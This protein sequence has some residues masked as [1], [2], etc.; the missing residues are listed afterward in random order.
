M[1]ESERAETIPGGDPAFRRERPL[2]VTAGFD[3]VR[4]A[5]GV[6]LRIGDC[7]TVIAREHLGQLQTAIRE[8]AERAEFL[9]AGR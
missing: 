6:Q 2:D 3:P 5:T 1:S 8:A 7:A 9:D 4:Q